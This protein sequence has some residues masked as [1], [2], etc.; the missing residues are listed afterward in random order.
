MTTDRLYIAF[1]TIVTKEIT[2]FMRIWTQTILPAAISMALYFVIFGN[3]IGPRIGM[4]DGFS[5]MEF[6][7]PGIIMMSIINNA[8]SNVSSSFFGARF[9]RHIEEIL[10]AP[11]PN[12]IILAG[13]ITGG[14]TRG[15]IVGLI[16]T[17]IALFFTGMPSVYN[18]FIVVTTVILTSVLFSLGGFLNGIYAKNFDDISIIP[19]FVLTPLIYLGGVFYSIDLLPDIWQSISLANPILY[20]VNAFRYGILGVSDISIHTAFAIIVLF[21]VVLSFFSLYLLQRGTGI[22]T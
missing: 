17:V 7:A 22:K 9:Q 12:W 15:L 16:V 8:Y 6:I 21:I 20:M 5:Y 4:M 18:P 11:V 2:R 14:V 3:L 13:Y 1:K 19:T 10:I